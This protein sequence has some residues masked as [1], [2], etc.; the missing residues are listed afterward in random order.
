[1]AHRSIGVALACAL[2]LGIGLRLSAAVAHQEQTPPAEATT[3]PPAASPS[4]PSEPDEVRFTGEVMHDQ[5]FTRDVGHHLTFRLTPAT[6]DEGGGWVIEMLPPV[7]PSDDPAEF[8]AIATPPYHAYNDRYLAGAFGYS[9][10]EAVQATTRKFN[11]VL[12]LDDEHLADEVVNAALYPSTIGEADRSRIAAEAAALKLGTG[13][14]HILRSRIT[15]GKEG[16][17]D[18]IAWVRFD[19]VLNFSPGLTLQQV[20]APHPPVTKR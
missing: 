13:Q 7:E 6:A 18:T 9:A 8:A 19:V 1:M 11:F 4:G 15:P 2:I 17:P 12:S 16:S 14:L 5:P 20:L 10:R 3:P